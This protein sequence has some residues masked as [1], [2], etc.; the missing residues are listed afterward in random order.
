V[1]SDGLESDPVSSGSSRQRSREHFQRQ[2]EQFSGRFIPRFGHLPTAEVRIV[3]CSARRHW[4]GARK[5]REFMGLVGGAA[6]L[7]LAV[8][9]H[10]SPL[11]SETL[12]L[13]SERMRS[14]PHH[15]EGTF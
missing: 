9:A 1:A 4:G 14:M 3:I 5:R 13:D 10:H 6:A 8:R 15:R 12:R 2:V 7:P 11:A